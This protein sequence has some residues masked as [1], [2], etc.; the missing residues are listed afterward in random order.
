MVNNVSTSTLSF[1]YVLACLFCHSLDIVVLFLCISFLISSTC[2][3]QILNQGSPEAFILTAILKYWVLHAPMQLHL[4]ANLKR[5]AECPSRRAF[6]SQHF[7]ICGIP[8]PS[9]LLS[10]NNKLCSFSHMWPKE[11]DFIS[12]LIYEKKHQIIL[13]LLYD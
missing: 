12:S 7:G 11:T 3:L 2:F 4:I 9:L 13:V 1:S 8:I 5:P 10:W 6:F